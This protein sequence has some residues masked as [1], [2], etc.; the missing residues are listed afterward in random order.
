[1]LKEEHKE[2]RLEFCR[3]I[4]ELGIK[5]EDIFFTDEKCFELEGR[6][7]RQ[8]NQLRISKKMQ[9]RIAKGDT[10]I[11]DKLYCDVSKFPKKF[12]MAAGLS[13]RGP[14]EAIFCIGTMNSFAYANTLRFF[15]EDIKR[16]KGENNDYLYFQQDNA[17]CHTSEKSM[18]LI[19]DKAFFPRVLIPWPA[20]SPD[21][22]PIE[23]LWALVQEQVNK[24]KYNNLEE[25]KTG[26][27]K[28]WNRIPLKLCEKLGKS[29]DSRVRRI[30]E[31]KGDRLK[32]RKGEK[33]IKK[34]HY[35]WRKSWNSLDEVQ[36]ITW[37]DVALK[38]RQDL[39][40]KKLERE[41]R[42][43]E[44]IQNSMERKK[45]K[46]EQKEQKKI[47][48]KITEPLIKEKLRQQTSERWSIKSE[49]KMLRRN[50]KGSLKPNDK[51][52]PAIA[53]RIQR[54]NNER[55]ERIEKAKES[56]RKLNS[57]ITKLSNMDCLQYF[58]SLNKEQ[59]VK[60]V[61]E[62]SAIQGVSIDARTTT[63]QNSIRAAEHEN[64]LQINDSDIV[65]E[66]DSD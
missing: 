50:Q 36:K 27:I 9:K 25:L 30:I 65:L 32:R 63:V 59:Q 12:M 5:G 47:K 31:L 51:M 44:K 34:T 16:M 35:S 66:E 52:L 45:A 57:E 41:K 60:L 14:G 15:S 23:N 21:L 37:N 40:L 26:V 18:K 42:K 4:V 6:P 58:N 24:K 33:Y 49:L 64:R 39:E 20:H 46:E 22:S 13:S 3:K 8:T 19:N 28:V 62:Y 7:N 48:E 17:R 61:Q 54:E 10:S 29:F 43:T 56:L 1:L 11:N 55:I 2:K 38:K 53:A